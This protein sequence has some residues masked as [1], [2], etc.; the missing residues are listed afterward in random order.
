MLASRWDGP[1]IA[2][3][4]LEFARPTIEEALEQ[5]VMAGARRI[6]C[7]PVMLFASGHVKLDL[8]RELQA[9]K[10][11]WPQ[12]EFS[13]SDALNLHDKLLQLCRIRWDE[14]IKNR[15]PC[16]T[17]D[18]MLLLVGRG[19]SDAEA[20]AKL[21]SVASRLCEAYGVGRAVACYSALA[22]PR[23]TEALQAAALDDLRRIIVQPYFLFTGV[24]VKQLHAIT[25]EAARRHSDK[26][27]FS[28]N[29]L[30]ADSLL[31][32][33]LQH[34]ANAAFGLSKM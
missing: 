25:A 10:R 2:L 16:A 32:D 4:F 14:A 24:L 33:V 22:S 11:R 20:N 27:I 19:S 15:P 21:S 34:R 3:A 29:H 28:T 17:N 31:A 8:P 23:V 13:S 12:V 30:G 9:A 1:A 26:E 18:T 5:L 6:F 7:Q